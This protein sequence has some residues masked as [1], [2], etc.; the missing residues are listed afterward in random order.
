[1]NLDS[2]DFDGRT[3]LHVAASEGY[4]DIVEYL[5]AKNIDIT[6]EDSRGKNARQDAENSNKDV[7][8][9]FIDGVISNLII[10]Q[11]C[12]IF[13]NGIFDKGMGSAIGAFHKKFA[14]VQI[15]I[16]ETTSYVKRV[17]LVGG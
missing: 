7:V 5:I 2:L 12:K 1:M 17:S 9:A 16:N 6:I 14:D 10:K 11:Q 15:K 13:T 8:H 4:L 3:A